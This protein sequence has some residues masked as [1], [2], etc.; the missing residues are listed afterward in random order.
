[1]EGTVISTRD[2]ANLAF[3][4]RQHSARALLTGAVAPPPVA[5]SAL[6]QVCA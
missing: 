3:Y 5:A 1:M 2:S 4:G 6:Y